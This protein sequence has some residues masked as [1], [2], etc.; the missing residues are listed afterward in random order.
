[1]QMHP[2]PASRER[3][4]GGGEIHAAGGCRCCRCGS[5]AA[6][7]SVVCLPVCSRPT[8][9]SSRRRAAFCAGH[10]GRS[11]GGSVERIDTQSNPLSSDPRCGPRCGSAPLAVGSS[12]TGIGVECGVAARACVF[13]LCALLFCLSR[14]RSSGAEF[15]PEVVGRDPTPMGQLRAGSGRTDT[16]P[17][18]AA[19]EGSSMETKH[20]ER[21]RETPRTAGPLPQQQLCDRGSDSQSE[22]SSASGSQRRQ[23]A[24]GMR[25]DS[26][27]PMLTPH[28]APHPLPAVLCVWRHPCSLLGRRFL[29]L[30]LCSASCTGRPFTIVAPSTLGL[31]LLP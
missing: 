28:A 16:Q 30:I 19:G 21:E 2:D 11:A 23:T 25:A 24:Q 26:S 15:S 9:D 12:G 5:V 17:S 4:Q 1:M 7:A 13:R 20:S 29:S 3:G 8:N 27:E 10:R 6:A 22:Q 18:A 31:S 14:P